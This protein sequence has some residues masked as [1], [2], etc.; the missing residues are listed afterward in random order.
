LSLRQ[1]QI[2]DLQVNACG[3]WSNP[4]GV[5]Y[6]ELPHVVPVFTSIGANVAPIA[7]YEVG[8]P[9]EFAFLVKCLSYTGLTPGTLIQVQWP[10]GRYLQSNPVD[11]FSFCGTGKRARWLERP[12][13]C[14]PN[15][16]IRLKL[17]NSLVG[18]QSDIEMYFEGVLRV[19]MVNG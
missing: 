16:K 6:L 18:S 1:L 9:A 7:D 8:T 11:M 13:L 2:S 10:D 14:P 3:K 17:D 12:K 4:S 15:T 5:Q 19:P